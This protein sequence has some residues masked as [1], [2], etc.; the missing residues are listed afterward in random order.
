MFRFN[1]IGTT[2]HGR[3]KKE[4]LVGDERLAAEQAGYI[5]CSYQAIQWFTIL[6]MP[7]IPLGTYR[8]MKIRQGFFTLDAAQ[9]RMVRIEW[10]WRQV[11][12]HYLVAYSWVVAILIILGLSGR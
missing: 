7:V 2:I 11:L 5:P 8:V 6:F 10:D 12:L 9:Y 4:D 1:G 3:S